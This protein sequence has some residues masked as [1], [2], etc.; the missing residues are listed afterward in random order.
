MALTIDNLEIKIDSDAGKATSGIDSLA[1]TLEKLK[2]IV[3]GASGLSSSLGQIAK[4]MRDLRSVGKINL[5]SQIGEMKK[6]QE[7]IPL[8]TN[9]QASRF[10][11][12]IGLIGAGIGKL[13]NLP[14]PNLSSFANGLK[15]L[16]DIAQE[17]NAER[18]VLFSTQMK[19]V[20]DG[21]SQLN[22]VE[23]GNLG[24]VV[25]QLKKIP[26]ITKSLDPDTMNQFADSIKRLTEILAPLASEMESVSK[27]FSLLPNRMRSA[28]RASNQVEKSNARLNR[29][30]NGLFTSLSRTA[31]RFWTLYYSMQRI[32]NVFADAFNE[33]NEYIES[34]NLFK[35][36]MGERA[37]AAYEFAE[38]VEEVMGINIAEWITNQGSFM[39][40]STGFGIATEQAEIMSQNLT[41]LA[42][43]M[44]S[45]FNVDVQTAMDKLQSGMSGQIK[46]LKEWGYN[47]SVAALQETALSLGIEQ[48]VRTMTEAQKA[49][50]RYITLI[51]KSQGVM[52]DM[53]K[54]IATPANSMRILNA[55]I[56]RMQ[57][58]F[59]NVVS[60]LI[61]KYI[62]YIMAFVELM[63][64]AANALADAWGFEIPDLPD[65]NL[66]MGADL[67][68]GIGD[69]VD[70]TTEKVKELKHQL[71]G[72]D[73]INLLKSKDDDGDGEG[74]DIPQYDLG[75]K[76]PSYD[77][78]EGLSDDF[79]KNVDKI[80]E[81]MRGFIEVADELLAIGAGIAA[82]FAFNWV[83]D[84]ITKF[85]NLTT[86]VAISKA[87]SG[88]VQNAQLVFEG[89]GSYVTAL[90][91]GFKYLW[92][93]FTSF[94]KNLS[95]VTKGLISIIGLFTEFSVAKDS[96]YEVAQGTKT[97]GQAF[98]NIIPIT[99]AVGVAMYAMLGPWGA[100]A[101]VVTSAMG[102]LIGYTEAQIDLEYEMRKT[103]YYDIQGEAIED[104]RDAL[105]SYFDAMNFDKQAEWVRMIEDA[106]ESYDDARYSYDEMWKT[107]SE[108]TE[109]DTSDIEALTKAFN[110][111]AN[112]ATN[113]NNVKI[114]SLME[115]IKLGIETNIVPEL[116]ARLE[117]LKNELSEI[118]VLLGNDMSNA[119]K[120]YADLMK[121][122]QENGGVMTEEQKAEA[123]RLQKEI[124]NLTIG[125]D[126]AKVRWERQLQEFKDAVI[127]AGGDKDSIL[128]NVTD[129]IG[130]REAYI[131]DIKAKRDKDYATLEDLVSKGYLD[132]EYLS[133]YEAAVQSQISAIN[134]EYD[135]VLGNII[136][137]YEQNALDYDTYLG[138]DAP[139]FWKRAQA[140]VGFSGAQQWM[141]NRELAIEQHSLLDALKGFFSAEYG[142][143][144]APAFRSVDGSSA[145]AQTSQK[146]GVLGPTLNAAT[147]SAMAATHD[148]EVES[149][150]RIVVQV[151]DSAVG[152][153]AI[154]FINGKIVQTGTS[155]IL[156]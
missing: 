54:T 26:E 132:K 138:E 11:N 109:L 127:N 108:K 19:G 128:A 76:L 5:T 24:N 103:D 45:F 13:S 22:A 98:T 7:V 1:E 120:D 105:T 118:N 133:T 14:K 78:M 101:A 106:Q 116:E 151:G 95:P 15:H 136:K 96:M 121:D 79:R 90:G 107:I 34:L 28:I 17:L 35:V 27:G 146:G 129:L 2:T 93:S 135:E 33:S 150:A 18:L 47:L 130:D 110:D 38:A 62:P 119:M 83:V 114:N 31:A 153:A 100:V 144:R 141:A 139:V 21:L 23:K 44:S 82:I 102:A 145:I 37:D 56:E 42:Y 57:R 63:E 115:S 71:M 142:S 60:V 59:G 137:T 58:A 36:S 134:R 94:M 65:N 32:V 66:D 12:N 53:A 50:L 6:L 140:L 148:G 97:L 131:E 74:L 111:L 40:M 152:E 89:T 55:Q 126:E 46:G 123:V 64:E 99:A 67:M 122:V 43:D 20:A 91:G 25:N 72:F 113:L 16:N 155:P 52:G 30:Y 49:Q 68:E 9:S 143:G 87:I 29:S 117:G 88:A 154:R 39:R 48:S 61:T 92:T 147:Q 125:G 104:V 156:S 4:G 10:A 112:A 75:I 73:E 124:E 84:S 3:G 77:F 81:E 86:I 80:K 51:Q 69:E 70:N 85:K 41:Q 149:N 8:F